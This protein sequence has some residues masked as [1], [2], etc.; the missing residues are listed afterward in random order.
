MDSQCNIYRNALT[1]FVNILKSWQNKLFAWRKGDEQ[2]CLK[3]TG[4]MEKSLK[5]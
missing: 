4:N 2:K 1:D 5:L 3:V